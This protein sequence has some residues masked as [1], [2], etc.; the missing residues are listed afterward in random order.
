MQG[1]FL[2]CS[3][4]FIKIAKR[5]TYFHVYG[6]KATNILIKKTFIYFNTTMNSIALSVGLVSGQIEKVKWVVFQR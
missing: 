1:E 3:S 5:E 4:L 2:F 6:T